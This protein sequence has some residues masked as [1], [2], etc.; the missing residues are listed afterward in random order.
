MRIA[1]LTGLG[2]GALCGFMHFYALTGASD[3]MGGFF[4]YAPL[5]VFF[6]A[7]YFSIKRTSTTK[8]N[9]QIGFKDS[10]KHGGLTAAIMAFMIGIGFFVALTHQDVYAGLAYMQENNFTKDQIIETLGK[11]T[12]QNMFDRAKFFAMPYFLLGFIMTAGIAFMMR[13]RAMKKG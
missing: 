3:S 10:L 2:A 5:I 1:L 6:A 7:I 13:M 11:I 12:R 9:N 8:F 4:H